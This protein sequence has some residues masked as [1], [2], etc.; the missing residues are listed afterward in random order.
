MLVLVRERG[1]VLAVRLGRRVVP[2]PPLHAGQHHRLAREFLWR[3]QPLRAGVGQSNRSRRIEIARGIGPEPIRE[4]QLHQQVIQVVRRAAAEAVAEAARQALH[5]GPLGGRREQP[6]LEIR[7]LARLRRFGDFAAH[8]RRPPELHRSGG[9]VVLG[10]DAAGEPGQ[11]VVAVRQRVVAEARIAHVAVPGVAHAVGVR[12]NG[13]LG[14]ALAA[15]ALVALAPGDDFGRV[16]AGMGGIDWKVEG[17]LVAAAPQQQVRRFVGSGLDRLPAVVVCRI[18]ELQPR[19]LDA[20]LVQHAQIVEKDLAVVAGVVIVEVVG[21][22][23]AKRC[24][25]RR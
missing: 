17:A 15:V 5:F 20:V 13:D 25:A 24:A 9:E 18:L 8:H 11:A 1:A 16:H 21:V 10:D 7:V 2:A 3:E 4:H 23:E 12:D 6:T 22:G 19:Y 14:E